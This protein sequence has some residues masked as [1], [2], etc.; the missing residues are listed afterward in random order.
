MSLG[1]YQQARRL[2]ASAPGIDGWSGSEFCDWPHN[3]WLTFAHLANHFVK[4]G[5][6]PSAFK[7]CRQIFL[8]KEGSKRDANGSI[9][10][11]QT[12]P[13]AVQSILWRLLASSFVKR[14]TTRTWILGWAP[15]NAFGSIAGRGVHDAIS[16][17][18]AAFRKAPDNVL[19]SLDFQKCFDHIHPQLAA[20]AL[21]A[22]GVPV[23]LVNIPM[24]A[25]GNPSQLILAARRCALTF[26]HLCL[27]A[28]LAVVEQNVATEVQA[29][30]GTQMQQV[31]F[32]DDRNLIA[33]GA[34]MARSCVDASAT[35]SAQVGLK[36]NPNNLNICPGN[37]VTHSSLQGF[38]FTLEQIVQTVRILG[39]DFTRNPRSA[40][41]PV[42]AQRLQEATALVRR[43]GSLPHGV[44]RRSRLISSLALSKAC[45]GISSSNSTAKF[46]TELE[47]SMKVALFRNNTAATSPL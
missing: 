27:V 47:Q 43:I 24:H 44:F 10:C 33:K 30:T 19:V 15:K 14:L 1:N 35:I 22:M 3:A 5:S 38:A 39:V 42:A 4:N 34:Q 9:L 12:R 17:L 11:E 36:E 16:K 29:A 32:L 20:A 2:R 28:I 6:V 13:I 18:E 26:M 31:T 25:S 37:N 40:D 45:W 46:F 8:L 7:G 23:Q 41:R 21:E